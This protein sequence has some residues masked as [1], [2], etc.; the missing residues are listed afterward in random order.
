MLL[1]NTGISVRQEERHSP[2]GPFVRYFYVKS[3]LRKKKSAPTKTFKSNMLKEQSFYQGN[4]QVTS[5]K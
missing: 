3:C 1:H 5:G 4:N 2:P